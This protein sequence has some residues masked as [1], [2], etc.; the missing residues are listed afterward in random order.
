MSTLAFG[1][2]DGGS[3][4]EA[5]PP[6]AA[7]PYGLDATFGAG[8]SVV[9]STVKPEGALCV[10]VDR[11]ASIVVAG[12][13]AAPETGAFVLR[14]TPEGALDPSFASG[15]IAHVGLSVTSLALTSGGE[16]I[17]AGSRAGERG[18]VERLS[19][20]GSVDT[21]FGASGVAITGIV[22][23]VVLA[24]PDG[25]ILVGG[26]LSSTGD[27]TTVLVQAEGRTLVDR[28]LSAVGDATIPPVLAVLRLTANGGAD[29]T[30]GD[31]GTASSNEGTTATA[32][33]LEPDGTILAL[34]ASHLGKG[35]F[36]ATFSPTGYDEAPIVT[37]TVSPIA[38]SN[39]AALATFAPTGEVIVGT[40]AP[41]TSND[42]TTGLLLRRY[43]TGGA[44]ESDFGGTF[45]SGPPQSNVEG[46]VALVVE[47][48]G[49]ILVGGA[50]G[51]ASNRELGF[52]AFT[53]NGQPDSA[54]EPGASAQTQVAGQQ[55]IAMLTLQ[56]DH[57]VVAAGAGATG[58]DGQARLVLARYLVP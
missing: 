22:A 6:A 56:P 18:E 11:N 39:T 43:T 26:Q 49:E 47:P 15:G 2:G 37:G 55:R 16:I 51:T 7:A 29:L 58:E 13:S 9:L 46:P 23:A 19:P 42:A 50:Y 53:W 3:S 5:R 32:L 21:S 35:V 24:Q 20:D 8:G 10:A 48:N 17:V 44:L 25:R 30:F 33:G 57:K 28:R 27:A 4:S 34:D 54:F 12:N 31:Q 52:G 38:V 41:P 1:C 14:L 45:Q 36:V 40:Y